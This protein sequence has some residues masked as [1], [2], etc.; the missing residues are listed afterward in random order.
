[1]TVS[2]GGLGA[3][4]D[5]AY[6][7]RSE[8]IALEKQVTALKKTEEALKEEIAAALEAAGLE[9]ARGSI[10]M[11]SYSKKVVPSVFDWDAMHDFVRD[12]NAFQLLQKRISVAAWTEYAD[13]D[14]IIPGTEPLE[15]AKYNLTKASG[16]RK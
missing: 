16:V 13:S 4:I 7:C 9:A 15:L 11:F 1:V 6:E 5:K 10:A 2:L 3:A 14:L 12:N 8:R